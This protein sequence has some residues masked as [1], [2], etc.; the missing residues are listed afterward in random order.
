MTSTILIVIG[1]LALLI[2]FFWMVPLRL[3]FIAILNGVHVSLIQLILMRWRR[4][5]PDMIVNSMITASKAGIDISRDQ[6]EAHYLAGGHVK[7]VVNALISADKANITLDFKAAT[8][9]DLA[10]RNVLEAI[11]KK[12]DSRR[13]SSVRVNQSKSTKPI[14]AVP[15][16]RSRKK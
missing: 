9:I 3:W 1:V 12:T 6:L 4:V 7:P 14:A 2:L 8:A 16:S 15:K 11:Q 10:G 13:E 5:P